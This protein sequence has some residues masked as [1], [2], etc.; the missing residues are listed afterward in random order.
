ME[1]FVFPTIKDFNQRPAEGTYRHLNQERIDI[2]A[3]L[4]FDIDLK[5]QYGLSR[6]LLTRALMSEPLQE[7][8]GRKK[9][10]NAKKDPEEDRD[11]LIKLQVVDKNA[12]K[13]F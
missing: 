2:L 3:K 12:M 9:K 13:T 5:L 10:W 6:D 11:K 8:F 4:L 1:T 7:R